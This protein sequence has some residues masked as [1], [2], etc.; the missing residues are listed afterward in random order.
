MVQKEG[1]PGEEVGSKLN[2]NVSV[3]VWSSTEVERQVKRQGVMFE[4]HFSD[5]RGHSG[6]ERFLKRISSRSK[7][8]GSQ[9]SR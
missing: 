6:I 1:E 2:D 7:Q 5:H 4:V 3:S 8:G 9:S